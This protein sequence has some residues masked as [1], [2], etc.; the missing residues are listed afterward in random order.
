VT[1]SAPQPAAARRAQAA[2]VH[3]RKA[4]AG[5]GDDV[6]HSGHYQSRLR[7]EGR[8]AAGRS[9]RL[10]ADVPGAGAAAAAVSV[11]ALVLLGVAVA[12]AK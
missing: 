1:R 11:A 12:G 3:D 7:E 6:R 5:E 4:A 9:A 8:G 10:R 2:T